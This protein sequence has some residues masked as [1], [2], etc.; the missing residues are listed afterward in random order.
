[1]T[2]FCSINHQ[3]RCIDLRLG[4][5]VCGAKKTSPSLSPRCFLAQRKRARPSSARAGLFPYWRDQIWCDWLMDDLASVALWDELAEVHRDIARSEA[6]L[7][8]LEVRSGQDS[9]Q[10]RLAL[11]NLRGSLAG[12]R[13][14]RASIR[15]ALGLTTGC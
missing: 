3:L 7:A 6:R 12:L 1:M 15:E 9:D 2:P 10:A 4:D 8:A 11:E 5:P 14:H 13:A